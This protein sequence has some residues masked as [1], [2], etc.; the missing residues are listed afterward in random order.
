[1]KE[2]SYSHTKKTPDVLIYV[3]LHLSLTDLIEDSLFL[4][5]FIVGALFS[6]AS[7]VKHD[8]AVA[9]AY[10]AEAMSHNDAST[11]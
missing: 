6:D 3:F 11:A 10:S 8:D 9:V 5:Q 2:K 1:M 7:L 4:H